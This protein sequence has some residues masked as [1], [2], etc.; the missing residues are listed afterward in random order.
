MIYN[1]LPI[2]PLQPRLITG[3]AGFIG[4]NLL[5]ALLKLDQN[6]VGLDNFST[7][8]RHNLEQVKALVTPDQWRNFFFIEGDMGYSPTHRIGQGLQVAMNWYVQNLANA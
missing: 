3:A 2:T 5:E 8:H 4:S 1:L 6:V 7:G